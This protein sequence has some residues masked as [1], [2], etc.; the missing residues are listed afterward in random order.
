MPWLA[1]RDTDLTKVYTYDFADN[2]EHFM[3]VTGRADPTNTFECLS[4]SGHGVA[5]D[6]GGVNGWKALKEAYRVARP[7]KDQR[8]KMFWFERQASNRDKGG[9]D[10]DRVNAWDQE[11]VNRALAKLTVR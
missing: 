9:L 2:W 3:T 7:S 8:E 4:G 1:N 11:K 10:G 5:E 6:V